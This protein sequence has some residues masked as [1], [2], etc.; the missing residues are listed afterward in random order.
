[1][2]GNWSIRQV[3]VLLAMENVRPGPLVV[4]DEQRW[5]SFEDG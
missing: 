4:D 3:P 2:V 1:M 5:V